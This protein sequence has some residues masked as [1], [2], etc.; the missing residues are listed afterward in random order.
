M[1]VYGIVEDEFGNPLEDARVV[2]YNAT[3]NIEVTT[4]YTNATG[5]FKVELKIGMYEI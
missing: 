3:S 1:L 2:I 5:F 4:V